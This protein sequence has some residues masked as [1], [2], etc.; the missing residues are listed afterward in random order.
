MPDK[1]RLPVILHHLDGWSEAEV[2]QILGCKLGTI[3]GRLSR[4]RQI[5]KER[6]EARGIRGIM[7]PGVPTAELSDAMRR[8]RQRVTP[9]AGFVALA[10]RAGALIQ[11][12]G[13]VP[14]GTV[15]TQASAL[16]DGVLRVMR[17][18]K[19]RAIAAVVVVFAVIVGSIVGL[20]AF[21]AAPRS[22]TGDLGSATAAPADAK[23][24]FFPRTARSDNSITGFVVDAEGKPV[25]DALIRVYANKSDAAAGR[26]AIARNW[27]RTDGSFTIDNVT[28]GKDRYAPG[29]MAELAIATKI[30]GKPGKAAVSLIGV[31]DS[32]GQLVPLP[33]PDAMSRVQPEVGTSSPA[34]GTLDGQA[35]ALGRIRGG[36]AAAATVLRVSTIPQPPELDAVARR[37]KPNDDAYGR[38]LRLSL[39]PSDLLSLVDPRAVIVVGTR[40]PEDVENWTAWVAKEKP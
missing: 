18:S 36:N 19:I 20:I 22:E 37:G 1:Y 24:Y 29:Q 6:L 14:A 4:G 32:L 8:D 3:S 27:S 7:S 25:V 11:R 15:S 30:G 5:L 2:A 40:L 31:D 16:S 9:A 39:L 33:G 12:E 34:F 13:A 10:C 17:R 21:Y 23:N 28:P 26:R 35:L 38:R